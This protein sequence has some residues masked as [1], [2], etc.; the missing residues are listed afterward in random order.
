MTAPAPEPEPVSGG[1]GSADGAVPCEM[2]EGTTYRLIIDGRTLSA[3]C[4]SCHTWMPLLSATP[5]STP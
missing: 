4:T 1:S 2:C 3:E 5:G